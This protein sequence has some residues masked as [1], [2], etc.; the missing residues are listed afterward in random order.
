M[1]AKMQK[2]WFDY[3]PRVNRTVPKSF[4]FCLWNLGS[5]CGNKGDL[6]VWWNKR[7]NCSPYL[8][9]ASFDRDTFQSCFQERQFSEFALSL[10]GTFRTSFVRMSYMSSHSHSVQFWSCVYQSCT[11]SMAGRTW[12]VLFVSVLLKQTALLLLGHGYGNQPFAACEFKIS[13]DAPCSY[14]LPSRFQIK[15]AAHVCKVSSSKAKEI[16]L[17]QQRKPSL[18]Q[19]SWS[20]S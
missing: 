8:H 15:A 7:W 6:H 13:R 11:W 16:C 5:S 12:G 9:A 17:G 10:V 20:R 4:T 19:G 1:L 14:R 3:V 18:W 2:S